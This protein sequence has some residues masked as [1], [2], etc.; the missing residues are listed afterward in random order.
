MDLSEISFVVLIP[1]GFTSSLFI[2]K[3]YI[4]SQ[5]G[6]SNVGRVCMGVR[7]NRCAPANSVQWLK[8]IN[9]IGFHIST[10]GTKGGMCHIKKIETR[11]STGSDVRTDSVIRTQARIQRHGL[12]GERDP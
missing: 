9:S 10:A 8:R 5:R 1:I 3:P 6:T 7:R 4:A 12:R 2:P 11:S